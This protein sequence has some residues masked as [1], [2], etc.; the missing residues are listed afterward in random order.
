MVKK[1]HRAATKPQRRFNWL[2][3]IILILILA[4]VGTLSYPFVSDAWV[5]YQNQQLIDQYQR[6][7]NKKSRAAQKK[8]LARYQKKNEAL[9]AQNSLPGIE[10]FTDSLDQSGN[11]TGKTKKSQQESRATATVAEIQIPKIKASLPIFD[12]TS[13]WLLQFGACLLDGSSFPVGGAGTRAVISAHRGV[14]NATLFTHLPELKKG[15][16]FYI[17]NGSRTLAY[18]VYQKQVIEPT[19]VQALQAVGGQDIVTLMTCTPY[20]INSE[21]LLVNGRRI[22]FAEKEQKEIKN[23]QRWNRLKL[24]L[25]A[26]AAGL[27]VLILISGLRKLL[28][29]R[30]KYQLAFTSERSGRVRVMRGHRTA[31]VADFAGAGPQNYPLSGGRYRVL[32][33]ENGRVR[34]YQAR[35]RRLRDQEFT[36]K[37]IKR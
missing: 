4:G 29:K 12:H 3:L 17:K 36:L 37:A 2:D 21:R 10:A 16:H 13:D 31:L 7:E 24:W 18:E 8:E 9:N 26:L 25:W 35:I 5:S 19:D 1:Q 20:M 15:D 11:P 28:I 33:F 27:L 22:P 14:P 23:T 32:I 6:R 34:K 30:T